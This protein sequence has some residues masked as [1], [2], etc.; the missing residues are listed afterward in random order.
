MRP[1]RRTRS[2][3]EVASLR[4]LGTDA[5]RGR[6]RCS[7]VGSPIDMAE[8]NPQVKSQRYRDMLDYEVGARIVVE[9]TTRGREVIDYAV[10]L[11]VDDEH[12]EAAT[13]RVYDGAHGINDMHRHDRSGEKAPAASFHAGTLGEGMRAAIVAVRASYKEMIDAWRAT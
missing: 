6:R 13:V 10:V 8:D 12:D 7:T 5:A 11:T 2:R 4:A 9:F 3:V 1:L